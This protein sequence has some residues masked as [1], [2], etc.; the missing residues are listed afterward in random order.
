MARSHTRRTFLQAGIATAGGVALAGGGLA[1]LRGRADPVEGLRVLS[2]HHFRTLA[3]LAAALFP[4]VDPFGGGATGELLARRFDAFLADEPPWNQGDLRDALTLLEY[5]PV[6]FDG[7]VRTFSHLGE[8]A[9]LACFQSWRASPHA[10]LRQASTALHRF[11]TVVYYDDPAVWP[12]I[13]YEGPQVP[14]DEED[15]PENAR[16][17]AP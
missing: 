12:A 1:A 4:R 9:R 11:L 14:P 8:P 16:G 3:L 7:H 17:T 10:T 5:G 2:P 13:G 15:A 6:F